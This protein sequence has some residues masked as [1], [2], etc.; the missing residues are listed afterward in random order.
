MHSRTD[1]ILATDL[2][3]TFLPPEGNGGGSDLY[4]LIR[5]NPGKIVLIFVTGRAYESILSLLDD[6]S[7]PVPDYIIADVGAT[8]LKRQGDTFSPVMPLQQE[9]AEK[10]PGHGPFLGGGG[11]LGGGQRKEPPQDRLF[12]FL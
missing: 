6:P 2:D 8:I 10:W 5:D 3:G 7:V 11:W 4:K 9:I 12:F 1:L